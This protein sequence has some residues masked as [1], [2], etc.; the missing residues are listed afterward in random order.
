[1]QKIP[2][3]VN[4]ENALEQNSPVN[5]PVQLKKSGYKSPQAQKP[6]VQTKQGQKQP[7]QTKAGKKE[8]IQSKQRPVNKTGLPDNLKS[9]IEAMSG[10]SMDDVKVHYNSDK[11][12]QLKAHAYAQGN[13][14]HVASGQERH[15]PHEAWHV[16]Q[17]KQ[18]RVK[19]TTQVGNV[20]VNDNAGL[21]READVMGDKAV[22]M[23]AQSSEGGQKQGGSQ[24]VLQRK[25]VQLGGEQ[26]F[27]PDFKQGNIQNDD[28]VQRAV[29]ALDDDGII[30]DSAQTVANVTNAT[31]GA[32]AE[33]GKN[34]TIHIFAHGYHSLTKP[35]TK[36]DP[37]TNLEPILKG[38]ITAAKLCQMMIEEGW[39][40]EHTGTIDLR[41][42][43]SGAESLLPSF[44]ELFATELKKLGRTNLVTGYKHLTTTKGDGSEVAQKSTVSKMIDTAIKFAKQYNP[45]DLGQEFFVAEVVG[46]FESRFEGLELCRK[47][48]NE[49]AEKFSNFDGLWVGKPPQEANMS[50]MEWNVYSYYYAL[51]TKNNKLLQ[52]IGTDFERN[53]YEIEKLVGGKHGRSFNPDN[54]VVP[55]VQEVQSDNGEL[56]DLLARLKDL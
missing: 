53:N 13:N 35:L 5:K 10:H 30:V 23:K 54:M 39:S 33:V 14:I 26:R 28:V 19:P 27:K 4:P 36:D 16:V 45:K 37:T 32:F 24:E 48:C 34:E 46:M 21:E 8:P 43:M 29:I 12:A 42:C 40:E 51:Y 52:A 2:K 55:Q 49:M 38:G 44:A 41:A 11:P 50:Q 22:Q 56:D 3:K 6:P 17:Q 47:E 31:A 20:S 15:L 18:G 7:I 1:M 25:E 9:G